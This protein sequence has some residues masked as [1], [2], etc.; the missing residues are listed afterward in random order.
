M[1]RLSTLLFWLMARLH[2]LLLFT[3]TTETL[4]ISPEELLLSP[5]ECTLLLPSR[6]IPASTPSTLM[7]TA[8]TPT[9]PLQIISTSLPSTKEPLTLNMKL[10]ALPPR[11][12]SVIMHLLS[13]II[14]LLYALDE[15]QVYNA[16][17]STVGLVLTLLNK[18]ATSLNDG[19]MY[20]SVFEDNGATIAANIH[21]P[22]MSASGGMFSSNAG[23]KLIIINASYSP[24][25]SSLD[26]Y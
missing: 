18:G 2:L 14:R 3:L 21:V 13:F 25:R 23:M 16:P 22:A 20:L 17:N 24:L 15:L 4:L 6:I 7:L 12:S 11:L 9:P 26:S 19:S 1:I 8:S 5:Q 10:L